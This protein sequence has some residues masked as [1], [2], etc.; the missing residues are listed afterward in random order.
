M[1][2]AVR[3]GIIPLRA[4]VMELVDVTDSK[5]STSTVSE[6]CLT[7]DFSMGLSYNGFSGFESSLLGSLLLFGSGENQGSEMVWCIA[8]THNHVPV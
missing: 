5:A 8:H 2:F 3:C 4:G 1:R 7:L 6:H